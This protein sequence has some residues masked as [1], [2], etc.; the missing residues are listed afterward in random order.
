MGKGQESEWEV[1]GGDR[2]RPEAQQ[3]LEGTGAGTAVV[4][5]GQGWGRGG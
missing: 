5:V 2:D 3:G 4:G 1:Q